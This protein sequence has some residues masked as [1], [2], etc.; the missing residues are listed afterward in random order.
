MAFRGG[1]DYKIMVPRASVK[2]FSTL[3]ESIK[4]HYGGYSEAGDAIGVDRSTLKH[5][6]LDGVLSQD[7]GKKILAA[8]NKIKQEVS[9]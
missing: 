9:A 3:I 6:R 7:N 1:R 8:Y 4:N 2:H 5:V